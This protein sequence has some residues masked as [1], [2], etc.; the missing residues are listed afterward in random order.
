MPP[1]KDSRVCDFWRSRRG[2]RSAGERARGAAFVPCSGQRR[3]ITIALR[4]IWAVRRPRGPIHFHAVPRPQD[5]GPIPPRP[6]ESPARREGIYGHWDLE[7]RPLIPDGAVLVRT[8]PEAPVAIPRDDVR[9]PEYLTL[10]PRFANP[11]R[12]KLGDYRTTCRLPSEYSRATCGWARCMP[13]REA[14]C[15]TNRLAQI[16]WGHRTPASRRRQLALTRGRCSRRSGSATECRELAARAGVYGFDKP[17]LAPL[18][19]RI[20][21]E[22][23]GGGGGGGVPTPPRRT[24]MK[25]CST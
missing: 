20:G 13:L 18:A 12:A 24:G 6:S 17:K 16:M 5:I 8:L 21:P 4:P 10:D 25:G 2:P 1:R 11:L 7:R 3:P 15:A 9:V 19:A 23:R 22:K 14:W